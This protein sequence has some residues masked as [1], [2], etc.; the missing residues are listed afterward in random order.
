MQLDRRSPSRTVIALDSSDCFAIDAMQIAAKHFR[1]TTTLAYELEQ[2][3]PLDSER[4]VVDVIASA[5]GMRTKRE[6]G[7]IVVADRDALETKISDLE[8]DGVW[9]AGIAPRF[10]MG[11]QFWCQEHGI[12]DG[13]LLWQ[14]GEQDT[15]DCL[16]LQAGGPTIW[17]WL[18]SKSAIY[19]ILKDTSGS[20]VHSV[21]KL[22]DDLRGQVEQSGHPIRSHE[23]SN[24]EVWARKAEELWTRGN[25]RP[26][27]DF[28]SHVKTRYRSAPIYSSLLVFT[29]S[30][31]MLLVA[32]AGYTFW[33]NAQLTPISAVTMSMTIFA[34]NLR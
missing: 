10:L 1:S 11:A 7:L 24:I 6:E 29:T 12:R 20:E 33:K 14:N 25:W 15:W 17:R 8:K 5:K 4:M 31:L 22:S 2:Y 30:L 9:I 26:W 34:L 3:L 21:G 16:K 27:T 18:D 13:Y 23:A 28:R 32:C 19:E